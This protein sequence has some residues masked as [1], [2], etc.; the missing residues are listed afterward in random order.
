[1]V[2]FIWE[3]TKSPNLAQSHSEMLGY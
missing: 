3:Q 2:M 1:M